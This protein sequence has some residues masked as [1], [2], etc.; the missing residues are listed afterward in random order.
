MTISYINNIEKYKQ[1]LEYGVKISPL[2]SESGTSLIVPRYAENVFIRCSDSQD[3]SRADKVFDAVVTTEVNQEVKYAGVGVKTFTGKSQDSTS[4][5]KIQEFTKVAGQ[6]NLASMTDLELVKYIS[7]IRNNSI[8]S[9]A[10]E[11]G[12]DLKLSKYHCIIRTPSG[13]FIHEEPY[14]LININKIKLLSKSTNNG[15][16]SKSVRF[17]DG[18]NEY[19]FFKSKNTLFKKFDFK[20]YENSVLFKFSVKDDIWDT[21]YNPELDTHPNI[22]QKE[23]I[24]SKHGIPGKDYVVLPLYGNDGGIKTVYPKSGINQWNADGRTRKMGESYVGIPSK[25]R[26]KITGFFPA[27]DT[28]FSLLLPTKHSYVKAK[29]CQQGGKALMTNPNTELCDSLFSV[30]DP[31]YKKESTAITRSPIQ[32]SDLTSIGKDCVIISKS[33]DKKDSYILSFGTIGDYEEFLDE[34]YKP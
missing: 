20:K 1:F 24:A 13:I 34:L 17:S 31:E 18:L 3:V 9:D 29:V 12:V 28:T 10:R 2:F 19:S 27:Q 4:L 33:S 32:Y 5:E 30:I 16:Y 22:A 25:V 11:L 8:I 7:K 6:G 21:I 26:V 23:T 14:V 15:V